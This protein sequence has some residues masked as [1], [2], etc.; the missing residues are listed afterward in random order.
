M[1]YTRHPGKLCVKVGSVAGINSCRNDADEA[2]LFK[3]MQTR[4]VVS[5]FLAISSASHCYIG[6]KSLF[7]G[8]YEFT[9]TFEDE[10]FE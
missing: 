2:R 7:F 4:N 6:S 8:L 3:S 5:G 10:D 9:Y 1:D